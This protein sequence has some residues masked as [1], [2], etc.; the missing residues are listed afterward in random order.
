[1][2]HFWVHVLAYYLPASECY[3]IGES[4]GASDEAAQVLR[5]PA[6]FGQIQPGDVFVIN[7]DS[8]ARVTRDLLAE[9]APLRI[10][11]VGGA[12]LLLVTRTD[13]KDCFRTP[14]ANPQGPTIEVLE[15]RDEYMI[16]GK[17]A[18]TS[19]WVAVQLEQVAAPFRID[20]ASVASDGTFALSVPLESLRR[21]G[22]LKSVGLRWLDPIAQFSLPTR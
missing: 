15:E 18:G 19:S 3:Y 4:A 20:F 7:P 13:G 6:L 2:Y 21:G 9:Q 10:V 1:M 8:M 16:H 5:D 14:G 11:R 17:R 12:R 22:R